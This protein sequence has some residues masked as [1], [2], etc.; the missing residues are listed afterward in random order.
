MPPSLVLD[1]ADKVDERV[2]RA[3]S[4]GERQLAA[5]NLDDDGH[6]IL[7]AVELE[8]IDLHGDGELGDGIVEHERVFELAL[9]IDGGELAELLVGVVA[10]AIV[11]LGVG[12]LRRARS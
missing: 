8:V 3:A 2:L 4:L 12:R 7:G 6:E 11:E 5:G 9:F 1:L 10:L